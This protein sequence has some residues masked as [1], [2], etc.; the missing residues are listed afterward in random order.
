LSALQ[1][2]FLCDLRDIFSD[3]AKTQRFHI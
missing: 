2:N 1:N 3:F